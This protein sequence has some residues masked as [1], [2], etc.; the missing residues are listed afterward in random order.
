MISQVRESLANIES[1]FPSTKGL[2]YELAGMVW[3]H[4]WNDGVNPKTAVPEY[5]QNLVNLIRDVRSEFQIPGL[6][7]TGIMSLETPRPISWL[8]MRWEKECLSS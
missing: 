7:V 6:P 5:E 8:V 4:G 3:Y 1:D 2:G